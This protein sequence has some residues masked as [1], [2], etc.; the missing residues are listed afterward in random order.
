[1]PTISVHGSISEAL[2][3][4]SH[5]DRAIR[6][7]PEVDEV[8]GKIGRVDS[9][10]DPAPI[11]MVETVIHYKSEYRTDPNGRRVRQ[12]RDHIRSP[13]DIWREI[14]EAG[15]FPGSTSAPMLQPIETRLVMLQTGMTARMGIKLFGEDLAE[16]EKATA[17][18]EQQLRRIPAIEPA[19]VNASRVIGK[20]Y[21]V[22]DAQSEQ[23][24][25]R[26][27]LHNLRVADVL[28][29]MQAAVGGEIVTHTIEGR[30][31]LGVRVQYQRE[32][33]DDIEAIGQV[34]VPTPDGAQIPL[35]EIADVEYV[36]GPQMIRSED[37]FKVAYVTFGP[38]GNQ[39]DLEVVR[40]AEE[41][42]RRQLASG[43]L[44]LPEGIRWEFAGAYEAEIRASRTLAL[45]LPLAGL[46][47]FM[48]LYMQ[49]RSALGTGIVFMGIFV[50]FAGGFVLIWLY[51]RPWFLDFQ[52]FGQSMREVFQ[53]HP[54]NLSVAVWVGFLALFGIATD[55]GVVMGT[56][57]QQSFRR[58][59]TTD[60]S[61]IRSAV[62]AAGTR[63]VRACLMTTATTILAL[64]PVLTSAGRGSDIM[65]PMAIPSFGGM[66][67]EVL[68]MLVV[69]V[70]YCAIQEQRLRATSQEDLAPLGGVPVSSDPQQA[71]G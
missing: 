38:S 59:Q 23:A 4:L 28:S 69:P 11:S 26:M 60:V 30:K 1:M 48:L 21:L 47:I 71:S 70:L 12:W 39:P 66:A 10:L 63:R 2:E 58:R 51:G 34:Q 8:V 9:A 64:L 54:V 13:E 36:A 49:F 35:E 40:E 43:E 67:I 68:T 15:E 33:R 52:I 25:R 29:A 17:R 45:I 50:A 22:V 44:V 65:I 56:Y 55:D 18:V 6:A 53:V 7:V 27:R 16:L 61:D 24:R 3:V 5:Q 20:P 37:T 46:L 14:A 41:H 42:L 19:T 62:V 31:R 57:L 32:L